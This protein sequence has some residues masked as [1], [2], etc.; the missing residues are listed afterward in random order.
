MIIRDSLP[1]RYGKAVASHPRHVFARLILDVKRFFAFPCYREERLTAATGPPKPE[2][3][4]RLRRTACW[5][6]SRVMTHRRLG[7]GSSVLM[8]G[9][10]TPLV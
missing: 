8:F 2:A 6:G 1:S 10:I 4:A 3:Q 9:G 5:R 7:S